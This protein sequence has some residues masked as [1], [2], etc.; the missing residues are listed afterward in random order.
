MAFVTHLAGLWGALPLA[1]PDIL[2]IPKTE[3]LL[4]LASAEWGTPN[5]GWEALGSAG[6]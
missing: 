4:Q 5:L 1:L 6:R 2:A 3:A